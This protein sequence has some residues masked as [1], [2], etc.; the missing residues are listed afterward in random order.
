MIGQDE[1]VRERQRFKKTHYF[2]RYFMNKLIMV[3][4]QHDVDSFHLA[5]FNGHPC[6]ACVFRRDGF[7]ATK[8]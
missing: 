8:I 7:I 6:C 5:F 2:L 3:Y 1:G 4:G